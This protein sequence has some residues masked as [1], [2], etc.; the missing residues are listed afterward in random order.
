MDEEKKL[1][2]KKIRRVI[3]II[4]VIIIP[5][6][7]SY[8]YLSA[9]WDPYSMLDS[10]P[11]AIVNNDKG[12][13][14]NGVSRNLGSEMC[15]ELLNDG[16]LNFIVTDAE[17]AANGTNGTDY[18]AMITIPEDF[19]KDI[20]SA[21]TNDKHTATITY[22]SNEKRNYLASQILSRAVLETEE[23]TRDKVTKE[24]VGQMVNKLNDVPGQMDELLTGLTTLSDGTNTLNSGASDLKS[25][26]STFSEKFSEY[27]SSISQV[28]KGVDSLNTGA[29][30]L[31][32]GI[33]ELLDGADTLVS[34]TEDLDTL[35]NGA[36]KLA[37]KATQFN[38]SLSTYIDGMD[39][40][41]SNTQK[42]V[43]GAQ[44]LKSTAT[45]IYAANA[46]A[47]D[48]TTFAKEN[49]TADANTQQANAVAYANKMLAGYVLTVAK[50]DTTQLDYLTK[51]NV[52]ATLKSASGQITAAIGQIKTGTSSLPELKAAL[53]QLQEGLQQAKGGADKLVSG[54]TTLNTGMGQIND[55]TNQLA[56]AAT[57]ISTG[58]SDLASGTNKLNNGATTAKDSVGD[59]IDDANEQTKSLAGMG[60]FASKSVTIETD[61]INPV[62]NYGTAFA[63][64]FLCLSLWVGGLIIFFGI[65]LDADGKFEILSRNS[66]RKALRSF[67]YLLIGFA[68][69]IVLGIVLKLILGLEVKNIVLY[70]LSCCLISMVFISI[71]QFFVVH[72]KD[73]GKFLAIAML[74]LQL[75]S[76]GGTFPME[77]VPEFFNILYPFMPMT[78]A[79]GLLKEVIS[80]LDSSAALYNAGILFAILVVFMAAT[81][82]ISKVKSNKAKTTTDTNSLEI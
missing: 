8:F 2:K 7:Y 46:N 45:Q 70:Y 33:A 34:S 71:I 73:L 20:A 58:A 19:S 63:P 52:S 26:T 25:G 4:G 51:N 55:A 12:A 22:S 6:L 39:T 80:G 69:A 68:Q 75:T 23:Q 5:L 50:T 48:P 47:V 72:L 53:V 81:L 57:D 78:Y 59:A 54:A 27:A 79:I 43:G 82:I 36:N 37:E 62:P 41:V 40:L 24:L 31:D 49:P 11:V 65:F 28:S 3:V 17:N 9:F 10:L 60:D 44:Q 64:Y 61:P 14:I 30:S 77:T 16:S 21:S 1:H 56:S 13:E 74:I 67:I 29:Q 42:L 66:E 32:S 38:K 15:D 18:Y 76:C 35:S